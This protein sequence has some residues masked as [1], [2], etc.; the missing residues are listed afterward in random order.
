[1][2]HKDVTVVPSFQNDFNPPSQTSASFVRSCNA[3]YPSSTSVVPP[4]ACSVDDDEELPEFAAGI[5][6]VTIAQK[7]IRITAVFLCILLPVIRSVLDP[8][9]R[10]E[11]AVNSFLSYRLCEGEVY[12]MAS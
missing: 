1:M 5:S 8:H 2:G 6:L 11:G 7:V 12:P 3:P 4:A 9:G 10:V